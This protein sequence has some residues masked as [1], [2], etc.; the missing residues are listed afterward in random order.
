[1][2]DD[3]LDV[4]RIE[5]ELPDALDRML[6][7]RTFERVDQDEPLVR[8]DEPRPDVS[9]A[10]VIEIV[11][12]LERRY[13]LQGRIVRLPA[14]TLG[15]RFGCL[16]RGVNVPETCAQQA[17]DDDGQRPS[18]GEHRSLQKARCGRNATSR[19]ATVC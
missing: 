11:E 18:L 8:R 3:V 9:H 6:L 4:P 1:G 14:K 15:T 19:V 5:T 17:G 13:V 12:D 16:S 2:E 7:V 10:D